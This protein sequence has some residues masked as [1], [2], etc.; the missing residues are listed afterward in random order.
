MQFGLPVTWSYGQQKGIELDQ[1]SE[2]WSLRPAKLAGQQK[3]GAIV[4]GNDA[5]LVV[6]DPDVHF[7]I[8]ENCTIYHKHSITPYAGK[9][10]FGSVI[11]TFV[12]GN[13]VYGGGQHASMACG[14]PILAS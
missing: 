8:G 1:L 2:W 10:L 4:S 13:L 9:Q 14:S 7:Y 3:K 5:D 6:W 11:A 12:R